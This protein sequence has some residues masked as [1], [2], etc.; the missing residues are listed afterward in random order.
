MSSSTRILLQLAHCLA[1]HESQAAG[2]H[3]EMHAVVATA[4][5]VEGPKGVWLCSFRITKCA[6]AE[7]QSALSVE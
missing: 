5:R 7:D 2:D 3:F 6:E 4:R 1:P